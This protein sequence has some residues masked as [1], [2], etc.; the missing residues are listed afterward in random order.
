MHGVGEAAPS[1]DR[2]ANAERANEG[3]R[4]CGLRDAGDQLAHAKQ[5]I[6]LTL[7]HEIDPARLAKRDGVHSANDLAHHLRQVARDEQITILMPIRTW[8]ISELM[9]C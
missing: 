7:R 4:P 6:A 3:P 5:R 2:V 9:A 1:L 8:L